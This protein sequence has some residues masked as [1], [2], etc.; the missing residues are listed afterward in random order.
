MRVRDANACVSSMNDHDGV[1]AFQYRWIFRLACENGP[2]SL[3]GLSLGNGAGCMGAQQGNRRSKGFIVAQDERVVLP[4]LKPQ[5]EA[6]FVH[7]RDQTQFFHDLTTL[8]AIP[9][10]IGREGYSECPHHMGELPVSSQRG[11]QN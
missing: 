8:V 10:V 11:D 3:T 4:L 1:Q 6:F 2:D 7:V 5:K 9:S